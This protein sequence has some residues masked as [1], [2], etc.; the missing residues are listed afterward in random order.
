MTVNIDNYI[1]SVNH[2]ENFNFSRTLNN[3]KYTLNCSS[4]KF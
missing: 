3:A 2:A 4:L 1:T